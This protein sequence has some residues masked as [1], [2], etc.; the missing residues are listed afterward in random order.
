MKVLVTGG[1]GF[2][3][4]HIAEGLLKHGA[5][6][7]IVDSLLAAAHSRAPVFPH[8]AE[9]RLV[10]LRD[11]ES[12]VAIARDVDAVCHQAARVG[13]GVSFQDVDAYVAEN[14]LGTATLLKALD[15]VGFDGRL[16]LAS[17]MV[18]YGEGLYQCVE[19]GSVRAPARDTEALAGGRFEPTCPLCSS[20][21]SP[22]LIEEDAVLDPRNVYAATKVH[23]EHLCGIF[24]RERQVPLAT[25]RYHNVYGPLMPRDTPY[26]GVASIFRS[27]LEAG[28]APLVFEDG[29]QLRDFIHVSDVARANLRCLLGEPV[30]GVYNIASG[31]PRSVLDMATVLSDALAG[32]PP[33]VTG[34]YRQGDVRHV[35]AS[36]NKAAAELGFSATVGFEEGISDFARA[37]LR[38][39]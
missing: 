3:G 9:V 4:S 13:L 33:E 21:V 15:G 39:A 31:D 37:P 22:A 30:D 38:A 28:E 18:V 8:Q 10:D 27:R 6:V 5:D 2:I 7:I 34:S 1:G 19:H 26:A 35:L 20:A 23:Q 17:S 16:V 11:E 14:A 36:P 32:P 25:L 12:M 24:A 29:G